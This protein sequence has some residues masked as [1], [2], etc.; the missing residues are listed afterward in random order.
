MVTVEKAYEIIMLSE[1]EGCGMMM[2]LQCDNDDQQYFYPAPNPPTRR[3]SEIRSDVY[4]LKI[5]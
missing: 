4:A 5:E 3:S 1:V 2:M